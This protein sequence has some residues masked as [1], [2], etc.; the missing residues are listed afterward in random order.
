MP[1]IAINTSKTLTDA[2]KDALKSA[3]GEK[4]AVIPGKD[5]S[6]LMI[7]I[8]DGRTM[9]FKGEKRDLAFVE[10]RCFGTTEFVSKKA[11][12]EAAFQAVQ[13]TTGLPQDGIYLNYSEFENWGTMG[14]MK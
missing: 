6:R 1:Y 4:I 10:V 12:T 2:Q 11:F 3:L 5:E 7:D 14:S 13:E 9:Y 8:D